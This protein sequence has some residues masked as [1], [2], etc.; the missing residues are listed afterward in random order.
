MRSI[1]SI[2][3]SLRPWKC[4]YLVGGLL[5]GPLT[6]RGLFM[7][8]AGAMLPLL[9][10]CAVLPDQLSSAPKPGEAP[11]LSIGHSCTQ[12]TQSDLASGPD[13]AHAMCVHVIPRLASL[14]SQAWCV[15]SRCE[16][17]CLQHHVCCVYCS[18][19]ALLRDADAGHLVR[20][21]GR[22]LVQAR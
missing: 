7:L 15:A 3:T 19:P 5:A 18:K 17:I 16:N 13:A 22:P 6:W 21:P 14:C 12:D 11:V 9:G 1:L 4:R 20:N 10:L 2:S 8:E